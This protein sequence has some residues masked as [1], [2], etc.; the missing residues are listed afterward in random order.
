MLPCQERLTKQSAGKITLKM[1]S[2]YNKKCIAGQ[3]KP[4]KDEYRTL[5][6]HKG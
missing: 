4:V 3:L 2:S 1:L 5:N 6:I